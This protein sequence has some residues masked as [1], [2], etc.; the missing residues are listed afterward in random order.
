ML[1]FIYRG[2]RLSLMGFYWIPA[3]ATIGDDVSSSVLL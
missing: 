1:D 2:K 3:P